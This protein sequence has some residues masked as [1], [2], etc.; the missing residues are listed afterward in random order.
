MSVP[1][2]APS[3][4]AP[5]E[6]AGARTGERG[7]RAGTTRGPRVRAESATPKAG[8]ASSRGRAAE[9]TAPGSRGRAA[10]GVREQPT[11]TCGER[12]E[13]A[14]AGSHAP[15]WDGNTRDRALKTLRERRRKDDGGFTETVAGEVPGELQSVIRFSPCAVS[16]EREALG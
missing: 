3:H 4:I 10:P 9:P 16:S 6:H 13:D 7:A 12:E 5:G 2:R 15:R 8:R 1:G 11:A 14:R